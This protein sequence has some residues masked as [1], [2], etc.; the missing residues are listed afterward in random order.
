MGSTGGVNRRGW[1]GGPGSVGPMLLT[2]KEVAALLRV[3][4]KHVYR[5]LKRGLP[6]HRVGDE[7]RFDEAEALGWSRSA[8]IHDPV[9]ADTAPPPGSSPAPPG[10]APPLLAGNGDVLLEALLDDQAGPL[11]GAVQADHGTGLALLLRGAV[12]V[13]GCHGDAA[14]A[15]GERDKLAWIHLAV[16]ELGLAFPR[17]RRVRRLSSIVGRRLADRPPTAGIR[18][19]LDDALRREGI[20]PAEAH[21]SARLYPSHRDAVLAVVRGDADLAL[22]SRGW[23]VRAG[24]GFFPVVTEGYGLAVHAGAL[25]DP[26]VAALG[27]RAQSA[28]YRRRLTSDFGYDARRAG[29]LRF[30]TP[31]R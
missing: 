9:A 17:G 4:P 13:A 26:R 19:H 27:E 25:G 15:G 3:H 11:L 1:G 14:P 16:R 31:A 18:V 21:A 28:A 24:L 6:A 8:S 7:W 23:A 29:E 30:A 22:A 20:D 2:T 12:L 10:G 5:L